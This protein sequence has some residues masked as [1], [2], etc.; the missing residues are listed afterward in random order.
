MNEW[1]FG[2]MSGRRREEYVLHWIFPPLFSYDCF[3]WIC[4]KLCCLCLLRLMSGVCRTGRIW[5][6]NYLPTRNV[7]CGSSM[8]PCNCVTICNGDGVGFRMPPT[9]RIIF[10]CAPIIYVRVTNRA[11]SGMPGKGIESI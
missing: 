2:C 9:R 10:K 3:G 4:W 8:Q 1:A 6:R 7:R 11:V 5:A